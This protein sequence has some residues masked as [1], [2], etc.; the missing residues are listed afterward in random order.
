MI[1]LQSYIEDTTGEVVNFL[2]KLA[3]AIILLIIGWII[4]RILGK[5]ISKVLD[6]IGVD[7]VLKKTYVGDAIERS[8]MGVVHFFDL[9]VRW[10]VYL[11]AVMGATNVLEI[12][13][14]SE[15]MEKIV[16]YIPN[17]LAFVVILVGGFIIIDFI[18]DFMEHMSDSASVRYMSAV[19]SVLRIFL[20]FVVVMFA[21]TQLK[22]DLEIIY[23]FIEPVAWGVGLGIGAAIAIFAWHGLK[24]KSSKYIDSIVDGVKK[25]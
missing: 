20:Y 3:G 19:I 4:G 2:P 18:A 24:D 25:K 9:I 22:L 23:V 5:Y 10:F 21:L 7:D 12:T 14:L 6:K 11:I 15:F 16:S 17:V 1:E 8:G 13:F